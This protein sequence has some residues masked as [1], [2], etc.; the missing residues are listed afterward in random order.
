MPEISASPQRT[1]KASCSHCDGP[2][3]ATTGAQVYPH[4]PH[5]AAKV[6]YVCDP[7]EARVGAHA[8]SGEPLGT[9]ANAELRRLR[10]AVHDL[11]DRP[12]RAAPAGPTRQRLRREAYKGLSAALDLPEGQTHVGMFNVERCQRALAN[13]RSRAAQPA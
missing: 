6:I 1:Y 5:L 2:C 11:L 9:A 7:C 4:L 3:R 10:M 13:L 8:A 12:W